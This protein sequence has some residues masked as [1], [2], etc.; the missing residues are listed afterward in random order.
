MN[1]NNWK[2]GIQQHLP[3]L[4]AFVKKIM[5]KQAKSEVVLQEDC[6]SDQ[7]PGY[8]SDSEL[9]VRAVEEHFQTEIFLGFTKEW[10]P[11]LS[12]GM[13]GVE[14]ESS[15]EITQDV[16]IDF[17]SKLCTL[18]SEKL[19]TAGVQ[20][21]LNPFDAIKKAQ[22]K[23]ALNLSDY[24]INR[25]S[26]QPKFNVEKE[27]IEPLLIT[28]AVAKPSEK[29]IREILDT[30]DGENPVLSD[31]YIN[32]GVPEDQIPEFNKQTDHGRDEGN[33]IKVQGE[34]VE[35]ESFDKSRAVKNNIEVRN[36]DIL[37]D[38][39]IDVSVELGKKQLPLGTVLQLVK[40]SVIELEK[41]AGEPV[42]ILV[43]GRPIATGDVV[44]IDE[45]FGVRITQ[46]L[47]SKEKIRS[48]A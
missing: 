45:F 13:L 39:E 40:G 21:Q 46:L 14:E 18:I 27:D 35:F 7:V 6:A 1:V 42:D 4:D 23:K 26:V 31:E 38:V 22:L 8:F 11:V 32:A 48:L 16:V 19:Q 44:V 34:Y 15:N 2:E 9:I 20:L 12:A 29:V 17:S 41:M 25:I 5:L 28:M 37:K 33:Q 30:W 24:L 3:L 43:N 47:E 36:M 10:L